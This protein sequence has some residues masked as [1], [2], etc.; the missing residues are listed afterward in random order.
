[1][2]ATTR[3][4]NIAY[5]YY[6]DEH[7][8]RDRGRMGEGTCNGIAGIVVGYSGRCATT[9]IARVPKA[10]ATRPFV[11]GGGGGGNGD[12]RITPAER[13]PPSTLCTLVLCLVKSSFIIIIH[14]CLITGTPTRNATAVRSS[15]LGFFFFF[16]ILLL[17]IHIITLYRCL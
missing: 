4:A 5:A 1:M 11:V 15:I 2:T 10:D 13:A 17:L 9:T 3:P 7:L 14:N 6:V 12:K 8:L 16:N